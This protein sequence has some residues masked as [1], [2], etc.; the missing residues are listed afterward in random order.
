MNITTTIENIGHGLDENDKLAVIS[1]VVVACADTGESLRFDVCQ[2][3]GDFPPPATPRTPITEPV[4]EPVMENITE[5]VMELV[6]DEAG[7]MHEVPT[8]EEKIV[9]QRQVGERQVGT[10]TVGYLGGY[11]AEELALI[12]DDV[13]QRRGAH[14]EATVQLEVQL[15]KAPVFTLPE[16]H[17]PTDAERKQMLADMI[18]NRVKFIYSR[19]M[20]FRMEYELREAAALAFKNAGYSG[21]PDAL[22]K[23][24]ADNI[25][26]GYKAAADLILSQSANLRNAIPALGNLRMDKYLVTGA[27]TLAAAQIAYDA[28]MSAIDVID[29][30]LV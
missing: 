7:E 28:T 1:F 9:G 13:A 6:P 3:G 17:V 29:A 22:V 21:Q 26:M 23:R 27:A 15:F 30:S 11:T 14:Q 20:A 16:V 2:I 8:G 19:F 18:D 12:V 25:G 10:K 4:M 24:F 5:P